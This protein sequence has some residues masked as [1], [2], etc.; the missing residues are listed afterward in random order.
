MGYF[1][2]ALLSEDNKQIYKGMTSNIERRL[3]EHKNKQNNTTKYFG[4]FK[5]IL[6]K[7]FTTRVE[8]RKREKYIKSGIG[9]EFLHRLIRR[10]F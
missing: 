9:R 7:E 8:A 2:Y 6:L 10:S 5:L 4:K 1:V 3:Q